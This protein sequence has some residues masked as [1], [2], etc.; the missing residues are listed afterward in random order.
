M[1]SFFSI[2]P[3]MLPST[4][5]ATV[6]WLAGWL[7][8]LGPCSC[9]CGRRGVIRSRIF[10]LRRFRQRITPAGLGQLTCGYL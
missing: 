5:S 8:G 6:R 4:M 3:M 10:A 2:S 9:L 7:S 1:Q